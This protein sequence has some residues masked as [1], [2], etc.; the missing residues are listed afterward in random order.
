MK[1]KSTLRKAAETVAGTAI[2]AAIAGPIGAVAGGLAA[3]HV[4][5]VVESEPKPTSR[6]VDARKRL[7]KRRSSARIKRILVP[8]DFSPAAVAALRVAKE[9]AARYQAQI[10]LVHVI[11]PGASLGE[12]GVV[13]MLQ[14]KGDLASRARSAMKD[15]RAKEIDRSVAVS[16]SV[17]KGASYDQIVTEARRYKADM[18]L[19]SRHGRSGLTRALLGSTTERVVRHA[20][21]PVF[22]VPSPQ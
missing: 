19:I 16:I 20:D 13:P 4:E 8:I 12:S 10:R 6:V 9:W 22:V 7:P 3:E 14:V 2:G 5:N 1:K 21:C 11:D 18:I 15:L 17:R